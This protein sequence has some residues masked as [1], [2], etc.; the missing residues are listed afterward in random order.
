M[1]WNED[2]KKDLI[3]GDSTGNVTIFLNQGSDTN[4]SFGSSFLLSGASV[5]LRATPEVVDWNGDGKKDLLCGEDAGYVNLLLNNGTN[6]QPAFGSSVRVTY[7]SATSTPPVKMSRTSC[8]VVVDW[9]HDGKKDLLTGS[10]SG[11]A[12]FY[13]NI[14]TIGSPLLA[15]VEAL[16]LGT[17][18][19]DAGD[20]SRIEVCDWN[21]DGQWD[22]LVGN[23][24]G[25]VL[26]YLGEP[27][28]TQT[29]QE[30]TLY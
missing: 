11:Y 22:L 28:S 4:P 10:E 13:R 15:P 27:L 9:D 6:A 23:W 24:S 19:L 12:Y 29:G 20:Y 7:K 5:N 1:D 17:K 25:Q 18:Y 8:P 2:G 14:G 26:L 30:W 3:S 16:K 21:N